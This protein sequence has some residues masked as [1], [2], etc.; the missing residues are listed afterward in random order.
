MKILLTIIMVAA[1]GCGTREERECGPDEITKESKDKDAKINC[2]PE[3]TEVQQCN[4]YIA[5]TEL[6]DNSRRYSVMKSIREQVDCDVQGIFHAGNIAYN[7]NTWWDD[8]QHMFE[9]HRASFWPARGTM[10]WYY[11]SS[12]LKEKFPY[13]EDKISSTKSYYLVE[14]T[15]SWAVV[16][17]DSTSFTRWSEQLSFLKTALEHDYK[18]LDIVMNSSKYSSIKGAEK[19]TWTNLEGLIAGKKVSVISGSGKGYS[20]DLV[21]NIDY[22]TTGSAGPERAEC[23]HSV[24]TETC[25]PDASYLVCTE[26]TC[27]G[28]NRFGTEIDSF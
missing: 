14:T 8:A 25:Y 18:R 1:I 10:D 7:M 9:P 13:L 28:Y 21:D 6:G 4:I 23:D 5:N 27:I 11:E 16:V 3:L 15:P 22:V 19:N 12:F 2:W 20:R 26:E 17:L 24:T